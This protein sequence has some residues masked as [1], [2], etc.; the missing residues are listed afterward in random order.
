MC[1]FTLNVIISINLRNNLYRYSR[2]ARALIYHARCEI[3]FTFHFARV[4][5][6]D[7][8]SWTKLGLSRRSAWSFS[9][10]HWSRHPRFSHFGRLEWNPLN[11]F[12]IISPVELRATNVVKMIIK[13]FF[14]SSIVRAYGIRCKNDHN[15]IYAN[16]PLIVRSPWLICSQCACD[17]TARTLVLAHT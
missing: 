3:L 2:G 11:S 17:F 12:L 7:R 13:E 5:A 10:K 6:D 15:P 16:A 9:R 14:R 4:T 8:T 1:I